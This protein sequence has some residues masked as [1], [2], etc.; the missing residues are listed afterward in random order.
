[1]IRRPPR[2]TLFPYTTLFRSLLL[3]FT[4]YHRYYLPTFECPKRNTIILLKRINPLV[5]NYCP[6]LGKLPLYFLVNLIG[7]NSF[8][9][10]EKNS[11][12]RKR[13]F[14][15][16]IVVHF[17]LQSV[18]VKAFLLES[19]PGDIIASLV[20]SLHRF[21]KNISLLFSWFNLYL[22]CCFHGDMIRQD[23]K[24]VCRER[25]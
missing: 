21:E 2:S 22:H 18:L 9:N 24:S 5:I 10:G 15:F 12:C 3:I 7:V 23:R 8:K 17:F 14:V 16:N 20:E 19:Y 1:M 13:E 6:V 4:I 11:L 25:V